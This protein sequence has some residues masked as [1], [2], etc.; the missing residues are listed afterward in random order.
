MKIA[1]VFPRCVRNATPVD[2]LAFYDHPNVLTPRYIDKV[3]ISVTF[4]WDVKRAEE[5]AKTWRHVAPVMLGGP[6]LGSA[7]GE[8]VPGM[9]LRAD[10][11]Y[12]ITSR[13]C[14]NSCWFCKAWQREGR[15]PR[16]IAIK[17]GWNVLDSNLLACPDEH[18]NAVFNMLERQPRR[19][20]FTGGMESARL[21]DW[22]VDRLARL[23]PEIL[24]LA[25][26]T[27]DD[28]EPLHRAADMLRRAE[29]GSH[30]TRCYVLCGWTTADTIG[31]LKDDTIDAAEARCR[32]VANIGIMPM[33][34]LY[35]NAKSRDASDARQWRDWRYTWADPSV[36]GAKM[37]KAKG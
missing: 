16:P 6:A 33:A 23:R 28:R 8:F 4:T 19:A 12:T 31:V 3:M 2:D 32:E 27:P 30:R 14:P 37:R 36:V 13:G 11:G 5:L 29:L 18:I 15:T 26:D 21:K 1:R 10:M 9:F 20:R 34:M 22:H 7:G 17:D 24:Y 35:D 25:Y